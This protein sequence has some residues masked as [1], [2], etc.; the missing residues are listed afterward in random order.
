MAFGIWGI[1]ANEATD[2]Q[3]TSDQTGMD[4]SKT[5][6]AVS[7]GKVMWG[8]GSDALNPGTVASNVGYVWHRNDGRTII[9]KFRVGDDTNPTKTL[10]FDIS[11][12][13]AASAKALTVLDANGIV[14]APASLGTS[15]QVYKSL[16]AGVPGVFADI[17]GVSGSTRSIIMGVNMFSTQGTLQGTNNGFIA[18]SMGAG[19]VTTNYL[20]FPIPADYFGSPV[21]KVMWGSSSASDTAQVIHRVGLFKWAAGS[22][23][24]GNYTD[25]ANGTDNAPGAVNQLVLTTCPNPA[26]TFAAGDMVMLRVTRDGTADAS[27]FASNFYGVTFTYST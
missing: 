21:W 7:G 20:L 26:V 24:N 25:G 18:Q 22:T 2:T 14:L 8:P 13:A 27:T 23:V 19:S 4:D 1:T 12:F 3:Y 9:G 15:G 16:G 17:P 6:A 10:K 5:H 11:G